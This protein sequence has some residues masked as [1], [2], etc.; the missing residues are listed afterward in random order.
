[1]LIMEL[2][3]DSPFDPNTWDVDNITKFTQ[4]EVDLTFAG[5]IGMLDPPRSEVVPALILCKQ[6]SIHVIM[7]AGDNANTAEMILAYDSFTFNV[8]ANMMQFICYQISP[9]IGGV[10]CDFQ[11][12]A[13]GLPEDL[14][15]VRL[16]Y[17]NQV[18]DG[19]PATALS[20]DPPDPDTMDKH[21]HGTNENLWLF[22][23]YVSAAAVS[24]WFLFDP[25]RMS[26]Y[27]LA[28][29]MCCHSC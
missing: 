12:A 10:V 27:Q 3:C 5:F 16:L 17:V 19:L 15:P 8:Y 2:K 7:I 13:P 22:L 14:F 28:T 25:A 23:N 29:H 1:M 9:N 11:A 24:Y 21:P 18:T 26:H 6:A 20:F 4:D